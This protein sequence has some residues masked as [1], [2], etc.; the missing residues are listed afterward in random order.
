MLWL[1]CRQQEE[2]GHAERYVSGEEATFSVLTKAGG[3]KMGG[4][5]LVCGL[6]NG[7]SKV[8]R[9]YC[10]PMAVDRTAIPTPSQRGPR[11]A[12]A[13]SAAASNSSLSN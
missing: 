5:S 13:A 12:R 8:I 6:S 7:F 3:A 11:A 1:R 10:A 2:V 4:I 9:G